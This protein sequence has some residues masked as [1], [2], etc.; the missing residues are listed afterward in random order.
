MSKSY[1]IKYVSDIT[2]VEFFK[3]PSYSEIKFVIDEIADNFPYKKR[4][5]NF[6]DT[7]FSFSDNNLK[8]IA[9]YGKSKFPN[10][11]K[12][13]IVAPDNIAYDE[14]KAFQAYRSQEKHSEARIFKTEH[15]AIEWL[16]IKL[17]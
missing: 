15:E 3:T 10:P 5:W 2:K 11:N 1:T 6:T 4:L 14:M 12:I 7:K 17:S 13:A 8:A 16:K 9:D